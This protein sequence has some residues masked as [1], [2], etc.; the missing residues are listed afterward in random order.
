M[1]VAEIAACDDFFEL[2]VSDLRPAPWA[3]CAGVAP[4]ARL[5]TRLRARRFVASLLGLALLVLNLLPGALLVAPASAYAAVQVGQPN[6]AGGSAG[7]PPTPWQRALPV[8]QAVRPASVRATLRRSGPVGFR[9]P[10]KLEAIM[11]IAP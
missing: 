3:A 6:P 9:S 2:E 5:S 1:S 11:E 7:D 4:G 8:A 10:A